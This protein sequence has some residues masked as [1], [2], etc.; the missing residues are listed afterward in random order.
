MTPQSGSHNTP[1][2]GQQTKCNKLEITRLLHL[3]EILSWMKS[4][5]IPI[6][7]EGRTCESVLIPP[8][9]G[10]NTPDIVVQPALNQSETV[11]DDSQPN[12]RAASEPASAG[13][14]A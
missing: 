12:A 13:G 10:T 7:E 2:N 4:S 5:L 14:A 6:E 9:S 1:I 3:A 8:V 11:G